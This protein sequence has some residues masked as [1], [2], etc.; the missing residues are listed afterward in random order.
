MDESKVS[1]QKKLEKTLH[2][3]QQVPSLLFSCP[4]EDLNNVNLGRYEL[5]IEPMHIANHIKNVFR[6]F[7]TTFQMRKNIS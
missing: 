6:K 5:L 7:H 1:L 4:Q 3:M 2:G